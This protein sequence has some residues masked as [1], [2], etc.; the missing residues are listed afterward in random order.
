[1]VVLQKALVTGAL[2]VSLQSVIITKSGSQKVSRLLRITR[3][4]ENLIT[5][6]IFC[7]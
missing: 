3:T 4:P 5:V 2:Q 1:M 6:V 7:G